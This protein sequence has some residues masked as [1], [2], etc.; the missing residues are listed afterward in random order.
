MSNSPT[1]E[2]VSLLAELTATFLKLLFEIIK[3]ALELSKPR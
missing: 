2:L 3:L 1:G